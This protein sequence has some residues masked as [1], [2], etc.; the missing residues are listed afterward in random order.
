VV[1]LMVVLV[2]RAHVVY[3]C[4]C[5]NNMIELVLAVHHGKS[6]NIDDFNIFHLA[7]VGSAILFN[8]VNAFWFLNAE[9][10][11]GL[12]VLQYRESEKYET[13]HG[14]FHDA[15]KTKNGGQQIATVLIYM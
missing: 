6:L 11:E 4:N 13:H 3:A 2:V 5:V 12:Q 9:Q 7:W 10:G 14:Y 8:Y 15:F 1:I